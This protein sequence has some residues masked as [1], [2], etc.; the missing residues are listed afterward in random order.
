[1]EVKLSS[2][3]LPVSEENRTQDTLPVWGRHVAACDR[4]HDLFFKG[5][6]SHGVREKLHAAFY[7]KTGVMQLYLLLFSPSLCLK[8]ILI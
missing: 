5:S 7:L 6:G 2:A 1:M 3:P 8:L 4:R